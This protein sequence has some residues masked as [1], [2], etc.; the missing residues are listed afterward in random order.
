MTAAGYDAY[1]LITAVSVSDFSTN[2]G[3]AALEKTTYNRTKATGDGAMIK[4]PNAIFVDNQGKELQEKSLPL[5]DMTVNCGDI[6]QFAAGYIPSHWHKELKVFV[7]LEGEIQ[8][9]VG[10]G[11]RRLQAGEGCFINT[12]VIHSFSVRVPSPCRYQSFVFSP[13]I[14]GGTPGS[15]FDTA[16]VRPLL[17]CGASFL[18]FQK[19]NDTVYF[20]QFQRAFQAC[21]ESLFGYEFQMRDALS[22]ILL[23]VKSKSETA[24]R[25]SIPSVQETRL[26]EMLAWIEQNLGK[27]ITVSEIAGA[28]NVCVR[29]CQRIFQQYLHYSPMEYIQR[30]RVYHAARLL[31][32]TDRTITDIAFNCGFSNSSYFS[33]QFRAIMGC[34]PSEYRDEVRRN[35]RWI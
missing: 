15:I 28:A 16:Y 4:Q 7:L 29:E 6:H 31:S 32:E 12:E 5:L 24:A 30:K 3:I 19:E 9:G 35:Q 2:S 33:R 11:S 22:Q 34:A 21:A 25:R 13:D 20:E 18:K 10:D 17:E 1:L 27:S 26:K 23:H 14:I 8:I